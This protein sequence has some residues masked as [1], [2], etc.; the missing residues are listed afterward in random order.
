[1]SRHPA[2]ELT[3]A[4]LRADGWPVVEVVERFVTF[5]PPGHRVDLFGIVDVLAVGPQGTLGIQATSYG[6]VSDRLKKARDERAEQIL[7]MRAAGWQLRIWGWTQPKGPRTRWVL[8]RD[9]DLMTTIEGD[10]P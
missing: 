9:V 8:K 5:P 10:Q 4:K 3:L 7:A 6:G 2:T 1:V